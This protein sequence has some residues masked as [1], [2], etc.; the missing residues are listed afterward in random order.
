MQSYKN[1][2]EQ[3]IVQDHLPHNF[4][5]EKMILNCLLINIESIEFTLKTLPVEAFYFKNHQEIYKAI[6]FMYKNKL[7]I[8]ILTLIT[9]LQDNGL[10]E[11]IGGIKV[12]IELINQ[13]PNLVYFE[14]YVRLL[15]DK[16]LRRKLIKFG[17]EIINSG[18]ITNISLENIINDFEDKLFNLVTEIGTQKLISSA[19]LLNNIFIEL[20]EKSLNPT[21]AGLPSG[22]YDLDLLTQGFQKSDL[23]IIAGRPSMGKTALGL[24][25]ALNILKESKQPILFFSLE[26]SKEQIMYRLLSIEANIN[27]T[28]LKSGKL[29]KDDWLKLNQIIKVM[30]KIPFFIDDMPNLSIQEMQLKIKTILFEQGK[31][32]L[33]I[34]DYLQLM[35][36]PKSKMENRVQE[37]S[38]ITRALKN[39]ARQFS[40]PIIALSQLSRNVENRVDK[41]PILSDLRE[42]GSIEQDADVVLMLYKNQ[43]FHTKQ[44]EI[45]DYQLTELIIAKQRNGPLGNIKLKFDPNRTK[46][47]NFEL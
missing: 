24:N 35:Q 8:D 6:I 27:Q 11:K 30:S 2:N 19:E 1:I 36:N 41:K 5:A 44:N 12:L 43:D 10:L 17:Y 26:M 16:F 28:R 13:V 3:I 18:Y 14:E 4:L 42:S 32:G 39:L 29:G 25:I 45:Q 20:K 38:I 21:L 40:I 47:S 31:I 9:F 23:I 34:I 15:K 46:F 33:I 7:P 22:F 37:I